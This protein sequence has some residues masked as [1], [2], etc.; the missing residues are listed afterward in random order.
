MKSALLTQLAL[1]ACPPLLAVT[2]ATVVPQ[3]RHAVHRATAPAH[4]HRV[5]HPH[6]RPTEPCVV[7]RRTDAS[8]A[9]TED[10]VA[11]LTDL[12]G[13]R[14]Q[15]G[16]IAAGEGSAVPGALSQA[17]W[18]TASPIF[19]LG[20]GGGVGTGP[21][22]PGTPTNPTSPGTDPVTGSV[23]EPATWAFMLIGFGAVGATIRSG[24]RAGSKG[25]KA[26]A[27]GRAAAGLATALDLGAGATL[28]S[29]KVGA[30]GLNAVRVAALKKIGVCVCSAAVMATTATTVPPL[31][32]A[33]YA[34]TSPAAAR[35]RPAAPCAPFVMSEMR[36]TGS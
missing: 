31:R 15:A 20:L 21:G 36:A 1:C 35:T 33:L 30:F 22:E 19:P 18:N 6:K 16:E 28:A 32:Q 34:A 2:A 17:R 13:A 29:A 12:D 8:P 9:A 23:P 27:A 11:D 14:L 26:V 24:K 4:G 5:G 10:F 7:R 3:V 25:R